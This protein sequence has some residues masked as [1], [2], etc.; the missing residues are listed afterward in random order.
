VLRVSQLSQT[1]DTSQFGSDGSV[2]STLI[3]LPPS[4]VIEALK[5]GRAT[6][7][8]VTGRSA[9]STVASSLQG[10]RGGDRM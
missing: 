9:Y 4:C 6:S 7:L 3:G 10:G 5:L 1:P 2:L 8:A